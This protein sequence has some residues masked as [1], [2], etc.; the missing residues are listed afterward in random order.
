[1]TSVQSVAGLMFWQSGDAVGHDLHL[2]TIF[3]GII[4][5]ALVVAALGMVT[6]GVYA[7]KLLATVDGIAKEAKLKT[8]P[9]L[10]KTHALLVDLSPKINS[11]STNVEQISYTI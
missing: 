4:A 7:A 10:D 2:L 3:V 5:V 6:I 1:M 11:V 8:G 9:I